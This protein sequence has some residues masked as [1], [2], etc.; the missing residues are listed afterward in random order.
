MR[1]LPRASLRSALGYHLSP[2]WGFWAVRAGGSWAV[3]AALQGQPVAAQGRSPGFKIAT[4]P[5]LKGRNNSRRPSP[6]S[7][8][9]NLFCTSY[10]GHDVLKTPLAH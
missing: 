3:R 6:L 10:G 2:L 7:I 9:N 8:H 1:C 4:R 5:A